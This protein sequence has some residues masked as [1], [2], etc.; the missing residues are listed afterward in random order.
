M[1]EYENFSLFTE[2]SLIVDKI[3][4]GGGSIKEKHKFDSLKYN[5]FSAA[6][7]QN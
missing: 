7:K 6:L 1:T 4:I 3:Q 5:G 2:V